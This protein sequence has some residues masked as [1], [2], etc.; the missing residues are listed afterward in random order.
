MG[1]V[2][3]KDFTVGTVLEYILEQVYIHIVTHH[4]SL[5]LSLVNKDRVFKKGG[6]MNICIWKEHILKCKFVYVPL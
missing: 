1:S 4:S 3:Y 5:Q 2:L 6:R